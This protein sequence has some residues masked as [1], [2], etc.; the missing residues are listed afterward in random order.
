MNVI[1]AGLSAIGSRKWLTQMVDMGRM[2]MK[3]VIFQSYGT[4][5]AQASTTM[6][7]MK[8]SEKAMLNLNWRSTRG[9]S[10][11]KLEASASLEVAPFRTS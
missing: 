11:K 9:T 6:P 2:A 10:M 8:T 5:G 1:S 3:E 4:N 7:T